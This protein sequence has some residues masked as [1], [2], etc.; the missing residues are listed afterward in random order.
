MT[1]IPHPRCPSCRA[2][3]SLD[4]LYAAAATS[5]SGRLLGGPYGLR[6]PEC[7][8]TLRVHDALL[9]LVSLLMVAGPVIVLAWLYRDRLEQNLQLGAVLL[10]IPLL[11]LLQSRYAQRFARLARPQGDEPLVMPLEPP[12]AAAP[13]AEQEVVY[14][15][16]TTPWHCAHCGEENPA[17]FDLC[18]QCQAP[19]QA[20]EPPPAPSRLWFN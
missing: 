6:C 18:W 1:L 11:L 17:N 2:R 19:R 16:A 13:P 14:T 7:G 15:G 5:R 3:V 8:A 10:G 12:P 9:P 4:A 20:P